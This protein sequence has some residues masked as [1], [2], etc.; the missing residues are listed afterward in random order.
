MTELFVWNKMSA[1]LMSVYVQMY[2]S[3]YT[4]VNFIFNDPATTEIYTYSH[5]LSLH[6]AHPICSPPD[7]IRP[8]ASTSSSRWGNRARTTHRYRPPVRSEEHTSELESLL[9]ISYA[10][11]C[12]KKTQQIIRI[13]HTIL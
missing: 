9:R 10:V 12:S 11:F 1:V 13:S 2:A 8:S 4:V 5:T 7:N 6:D 3:S